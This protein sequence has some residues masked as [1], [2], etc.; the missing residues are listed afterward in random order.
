MELSPP[1][2][3]SARKD[4]RVADLVWVFDAGDIATELKRVR[5]TIADAAPGTKFSDTAI[6]EVFI[7]GW[8]KRK[9]E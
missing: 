3:A 8:K 5:F 1:K 4:W 2:P 7:Y 9:N 6:S